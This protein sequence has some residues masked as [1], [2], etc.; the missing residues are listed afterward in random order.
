MS[1]ILNPKKSNLYSEREFEEKPTHLETAMKQMRKE[2]LKHRHNCLHESMLT[3]I[4]MFDDHL[5]TLE[6]TRRDIKFRITFLDLF[7][8]TL[9]EELIILNNFDLLEDDY[10]NNVCLKTR[11]QNEKINQVIY[12]SILNKK[13]FIK[14][15][16]FCYRYRQSKMI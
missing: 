16:L 13:L 9:E 14:L 6:T 2:K 7:A 10:C 8:L 5:L 11:K 3:K 15:V 4:N 1:L 12:L